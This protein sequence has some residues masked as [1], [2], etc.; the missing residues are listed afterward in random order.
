MSPNKRVLIADDESSICEICH[1]V[2]SERGFTVDCAPNGHDA[3]ELLNETDY[4]LIILDI[5]MPRVSGP[6]VLD[7]LRREH[8]ELLER[9]ILI[10]GDLMNDSTEAFVRATDLPFLPK[11]F[12]PDELKTIVDRVYRSLYPAS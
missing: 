12:L 1:R 6:D 11:P 9:V 7:N 10:S 8:P 3:W 4:C 2:L 5:R